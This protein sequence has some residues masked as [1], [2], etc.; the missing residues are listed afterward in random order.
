MSDPG[1]WWW[2]ILGVL[3]IGGLG[4][5]IAYGNS[6][7][8]RRGSIARQVQDAE[9][10]K[11]YREEELREKSQEFL[12]RSSTNPPRGT[13]RKRVSRPRLQGR[14]SKVRPKAEVQ[15]PGI[16][17]ATSSRL[18]LQARSWPSFSSQSFCNLP[19]YEQL[20]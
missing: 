14:Q 16:T 3:A 1:G 7:R 11:N 17:C 13:R 4:V 9:T 5:A 15:L 8:L 2:V 19:Q 18:H 20:I 12:D 10:R 6:I